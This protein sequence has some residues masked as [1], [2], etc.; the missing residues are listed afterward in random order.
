MKYVRSFVLF[1]WNFIVGDDPRVAAGLAAAFAATWALADHGVNA[2][3]L[4]P[5][6]VVLLLAESVRRESRAGG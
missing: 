6:A 2:W 1:W 3:W 5:I 4:L